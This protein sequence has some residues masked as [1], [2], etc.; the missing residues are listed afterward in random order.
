MP[1]IIP[2][3]SITGGY[4]VDNS[5]RFDDGSSDTLTR[6][7]STAGNRKTFTYSSWIKRGIVS[8]GYG[9]FGQGNRSSSDFD[10]RLESDGKIR[11]EPSG[12]DIKTNAQYR[13]CS[14]WY[15]IV[16][17]VDT[18]QATASNRVKLYVNGSQVTSLA[19]TTY[20]SL[21]YDTVVNSSGSTGNVVLGDIFN[22]TGKFD[23]YMAEVVLIDGT[24]LD[25][26]SFGEFDSATGIWKPIDVSGLTFGTNGF[27][28]D[29]ENS[30]SLGA[31]VSGNG[32]NFTVN[33]LTSIDQSTDTPT[34]NYCTM[35]P[36][37]N[38]DPSNPLGSISNGNLSF[39]TNS[40]SLSSMGV[41]TFGASSGKYY[42]EIKLTGE[43]GSGEAFAGIGYDIYE[44]AT[45]S[46]NAESSFMWNVCSNGDAKFGGSAQGVGN[47]SNTYTTND[48]ISIALD[49][50][51]NRVYFA[52]NG[53]YADGS[54]NWDESFIGSPAYA[55][56]TADKSYFFCAGDKSSSQTASWSCNFGNPP[57]TIS[58][59]NSDGAGFGQFEYA[60]PSGYL[61][62]C[63]KNLATDG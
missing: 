27:Y 37:F 16:L 26:T 32:N 53:Q 63:T 21:N 23:G 12:F 60:P 38:P 29:F 42:A 10:I 31:D 47:W 33:N 9:L 15:H 57:F 36:L 39:T 2:A 40:T 20:P 41:T 14:A 48:I 18:T 1:L 46:F 5:L 58:S 30:G 17:A 7:V 61:S 52:K 50:D 34:N 62:L 55:T 11:I 8:A 19:N 45:S 56:I 54:G 28:L 51:N 13:D 4:E 24:A 35:N 43:S 6:T 49:L 44:N 25:P 22:G 3:N 59:G